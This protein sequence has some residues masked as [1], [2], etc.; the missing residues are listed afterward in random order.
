[1]QDGG[2]MQER[3]LLCCPSAVPGTPGWTRICPVTRALPAG[4]REEELCRLPDA[5][6]YGHSC[7]PWAVF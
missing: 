6:Q 1:M 3:A 4:A 7:H 2:V 5:H